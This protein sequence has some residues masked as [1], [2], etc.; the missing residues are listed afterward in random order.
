MAS[1]L[2]EV[3]G[4][5]TWHV[6]AGPTSLD[7]SVFSGELMSFGSGVTLAGPYRA[8]ARLPDA[9]TI[10]L[11]FDDAPTARSSFLAERWRCSA[12]P[13]VPTARARL[14]SPTN[15][16]PAGGG[17][18]PPTTAAASSSSGRAIAPSSP[19][20]CTTPPATRRGTSPTRPSPTHRRC[21]ARGSQFANGQTLTGA[22]RAPTLVN[23]NV[24]PVTIQFQG[25][26]TALITLPSGTLPLTRFRF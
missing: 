12:M 6:A 23:G 19:A 1:Y 4:R 14:R 13:S 5:A 8:N 7:G 3:S 11:T 15:P 18:E 20:T 10:A 25:A 16:R 26:D 22:Y 24:A 9:G 21:R 17:A 2:Y